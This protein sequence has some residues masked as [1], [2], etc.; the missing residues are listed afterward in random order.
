MKIIRIFVIFAIIAISAIQVGA[1]I[2]MPHGSYFYADSIR[3]E[4]DRGPYFTLY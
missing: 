2:V 3:D 1:Q 4:F